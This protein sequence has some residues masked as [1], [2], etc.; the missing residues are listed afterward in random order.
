MLA[1][2]SSSAT[3]GSSHWCGKGQLLSV[4]MNN[5]LSCIHI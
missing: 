3:V 5:G 2:D 4:D 1:K